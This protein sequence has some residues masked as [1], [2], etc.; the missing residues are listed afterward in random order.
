MIFA[1]CHFTALQF[2]SMHSQL[3]HVHSCRRILL[4]LPFIQCYFIITHVLLVH[5]CKTALHFI[6]SP[7]TVICS[8][9]ILRAFCFAPFVAI[10]NAFSSYFILNRLIL[11]AFDRYV[12]VD[13]IHLHIHTTAF[14][15]IQGPFCI[16]LHFF[17]S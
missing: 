11:H 6:Q 15:C 16:H 7:F 1:P 17:A 10:L 8:S 13:C 12:A 9:C 3:Y 2:I 14:F 5:S 4:R